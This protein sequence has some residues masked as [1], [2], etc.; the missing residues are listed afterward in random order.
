M[1]I[2][3]VSSQAYLVAVA[4]EHY[5]PE[6]LHGIIRAC[7]FAGSIGR[8]PQRFV[9]VLVLKIGVGRTAQSTYAWDTTHLFAGEQA[10]GADHAPYLSAIAVDDRGCLARPPDRGDAVLSRD[11][12]EGS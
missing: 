1:A 11:R 6:D 12:I 2:V 5:Q 4:T 8:I 10:A 9:N 7:R 3:L